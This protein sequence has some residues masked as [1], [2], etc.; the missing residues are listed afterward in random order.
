MEKKDFKPEKYRVL[1]VDDAEPN[2]VLLRHVLETEGFKVE[3]CRSGEEAL[4][5]IDDIKPDLILLDINMPGMNGFEVSKS[6]QNSSHA[7]IPVIFL[8]GANEIESMVGAFESG[9]VDFINKPFAK[10]EVLA[11]IRTHLS[12][13]ELEKERLA[14]IQLLQQREQQLSQLNAQK[15]ELIRMVSHDI[16]NP[17]TGIIGMT[18]MMLNEED[19]E[20]EE[21]RE[22]LQLVDKSAQNLFQLV[23]DL[24]DKESVELENTSM[25]MDTVDLRRLSEEV[26]SDCESQASEKQIGLTL[27]VNTDDHLIE[28]DAEKL[29]NAF[30]ILVM[31]SIAYTYENG[32][33]SITINPDEGDHCRMEFQDNGIGISE[34]ILKQFVISTEPGEAPDPANFMGEDIGLDIVRKTIE[35]HDGKIW[36]NSAEGAGTTFFIQL[37]LKQT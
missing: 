4:N 28:G 22:M 2:L 18:N 17:L 33:I 31:N 35:L 16:K 11:R 12:I 3:F 27:Q 37:P 14:R 13:A 7:N 21:F 6:I 29:R 36:V 9:G 1:A 19:L 5:K 20:P 10:E 8:S 34:S 23:K 24:L 30:S 15:N 26:I 25:D 32:D